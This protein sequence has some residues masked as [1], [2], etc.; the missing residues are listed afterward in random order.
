MDYH[1]LLIWSGMFI[2]VPLLAGWCKW[3]LW[4]LRSDRN[5]P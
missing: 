4:E 2:C 5:L 3:R 1:A